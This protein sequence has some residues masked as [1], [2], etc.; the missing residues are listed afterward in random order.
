LECLDRA[1]SIFQGLGDRL[2]LCRTLLEIGRYYA[3]L[4][5]RKARSALDEAE[6]LAMK[7]KIKP[8]LAEIN[9]LQA[10]LFPS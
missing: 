5:N 3:D 8:I 1:C 10:Q 9:D 2:G 7:M 4:D 6:E